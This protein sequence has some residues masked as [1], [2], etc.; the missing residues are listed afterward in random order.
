MSAEGLASARRRQAPGFVRLEVFDG[1]ETVELDLAHDARQHPASSTE[2]GTTLAAEE[3]AADKMLALYGRAE[4]RD[5]ID[6]AALLEVYS[7]AELLELARRKD[8]GFTVKR[9]VEALGAIHRF[10]EPDFMAAGT[11]G[12]I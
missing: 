3:L 8:A 11:S 9:F 7:E 12:P 5:F 4:V 10:R 2:L 1:I 6:A